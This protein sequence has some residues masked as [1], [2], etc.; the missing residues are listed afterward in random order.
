MERNPQFINSLQELLNKECSLHEEYISVLT[1]EREALKQFK[2]YEVSALSARREKLCVEIAKIQ[3]QRINFLD[4]FPDAK[5]KKLSELIARYCHPDEAR[6]LNPLIK[7]L[8]GLLS[9]S[10]ALGTE[11][12]QIVDFSL[13]LVNGTLS[14]LWSAT[15]NVTKS[16]SRKG[17]VQEKYQTLK[18]DILKRA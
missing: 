7:R 9:Q 18:G 6:K 15:Q 1:E 3:E 8:K 11:F 17:Q 13:T 5:N 16:Y 10:K 4:H 14:I 12:N 2:S